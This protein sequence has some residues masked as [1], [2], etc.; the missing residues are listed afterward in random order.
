M[1]THRVI[2]FLT[3]QA[4]TVLRLTFILLLTAAVPTWAATYTVTNSNDSGAG[5][6][7]AQIAAAV[8]NDTIVFAA[9]LDG[10]TISLTTFSNDLSTGSQQ[11]GPSA[12][13]ITGSK[14]LVIDATANGLTKG[15]VIARSS[16]PGTANFRLFDVGVG[17]NLTLRGV[18]LSNGYARGGSSLYA[19]GAV[20]AGGAIFNQGILTLDRCTLTGNTAVGGDA[21]SSGNSGGGGAGANSPASYDGGG[22][23]GGAAG[24]DT[25]DGSNAG[26]GGNGGFGGGGGGAGWAFGGGTGGNGGHGGFGGGAASTGITPARAHPAMAVTAA[27][28]AVRAPVR[29]TVSPASVAAARV[30]MAARVPAWAAQSLTM[31]AP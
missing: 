11:F 31:L 13:F 26:A 28:A 7:R 10:A 21:R 30:A 8:T 4:L 24:A 14:T 9:A 12:F 6:L 19:G 5:S 22:P 23:N 18:T 17:S 3:L 25:F 16:V 2:S 1:F 29:P 20:G 27:S 15:V